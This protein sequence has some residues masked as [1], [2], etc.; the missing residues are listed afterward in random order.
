[1]PTASAAPSA[2]RANIPTQID[3]DHPKRIRRNPFGVV[4]VKKQEEAQQNQEGYGLYIQN[5]KSNGIY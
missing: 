2:I 4:T 3:V 1:M 5:G